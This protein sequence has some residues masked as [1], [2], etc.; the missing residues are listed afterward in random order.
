MMK[1]FKY[2]G[3][4]LVSALLLQSCNGKQEDKSSGSEQEKAIVKNKEVVVSGIPVYDF[5]EYEHLLQQGEGKVYVINFWATW[6][7]PCIKELPAFE[8]IRENYSSKGVEVILTSLDFSDK[9]ESNVIPFIEKHNLQ[10][11]VVLLD[12]VDS[13]TWIPKVDSGWSGAIPATLIYNENQRKFYERSFTYDE[14]E[15]ELKTF[16]K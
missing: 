9:L 3:L 6:C 7:K 5:A 10:S 8:A 16:L 13:N 14:L 11:R 2:F 15:T 4:F 1:N 12:D